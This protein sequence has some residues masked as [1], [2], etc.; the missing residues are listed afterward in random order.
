VEFNPV[1]AGGWCLTERGIIAVLVLAR[2]VVWAG[3]SLDDVRITQG[4][5]LYG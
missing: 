4:G 2:D 1:S 5:V 3:L